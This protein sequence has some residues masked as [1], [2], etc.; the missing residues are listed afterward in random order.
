MTQTQGPPGEPNRPAP[1]PNALTRA[2]LHLIRGP[3]AEFL[4]GD[5]EES[6]RHRIGGPG[7]RWRAEVQQLNDVVRSVARWHG[8]GNR[9]GEEGTMKGR[10]EGDREG[11]AR[12]P[13]NSE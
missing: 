1:R 7:R 8:R 6:W 9:N 12:V 10:I 4:L 13:R 2:L 11:A 5:L 3:G